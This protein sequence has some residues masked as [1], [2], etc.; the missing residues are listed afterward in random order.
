MGRGDE[1]KQMDTT[2]PLIGAVLMLAAFFAYEMWY[3]DGVSEQG[4]SSL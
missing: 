2:W 3:G 4:Q 1:K